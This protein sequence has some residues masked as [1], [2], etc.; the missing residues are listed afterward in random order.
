MEMQSAHKT[1]DCARD[2]DGCG[3]GDD[4]DEDETLRTVE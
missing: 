2:S 4:D 3:D 1:E